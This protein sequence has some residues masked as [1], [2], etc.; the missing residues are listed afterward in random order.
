MPG[1]ERTVDWEAMPPGHF[2]AGKSSRLKQFALT[3]EQLHQ[4]EVRP[5]SLPYSFRPQVWRAALPV[6]FDQ[7]VSAPFSSAVSASPQVFEAMDE[8][9]SPLSTS[10]H[11]LNSHGTYSTS[12]GAPHSC[13]ADSRRHSSL[14]TLNLFRISM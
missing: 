1:G 4:R 8:P 11:S 3:P 6:M 12:D 2:I 14:D 13:A 5:S 9:P 7:S 10:P